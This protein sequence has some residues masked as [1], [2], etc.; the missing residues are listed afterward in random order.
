MTSFQALVR[1]DHREQL[2]LQPRPLDVTRRSRI[3]VHDSLHKFR[4]RITRTGYQ[5]V[6][7]G[8]NWDVVIVP[9]VA[10]IDMAFKLV[11]V[12]RGGT[13]TTP[14]AFSEKQGPHV[15]YRSALAT[16]R[17]IWM[18][19]RFAAEQPAVYGVTKR[20]CLCDNAKFR[21]ELL[22]SADEFEHGRRYAVTHKIA[23]TVLAI[24]TDAEQRRLKGAMPAAVHKHIFT[25]QQLLHFVSKYSIHR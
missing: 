7:F 10:G 8:D 24:V 13:I 20:L 14:E 19:D 15:I 16:K 1:K 12:L 18:S 5:C 11:A 21:W 3:H 23:S 2:A 4:R 6:G 25:F 22:Y 9:D 17:K